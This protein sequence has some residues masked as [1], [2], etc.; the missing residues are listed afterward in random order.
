MLPLDRPLILNRDDLVAMPSG[1][2]V[3]DW[4]VVQLQH[5][6][7]ND[8]VDG[9]GNP[10]LT[11]IPDTIEVLFRVIR[12]TSSAHNGA[13]SHYRHGKFADAVGLRG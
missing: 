4:C 11:K 1:F 9:D 3:V 2:R 7:G 13:K 12:C 10:V 5:A 8:H 6:D